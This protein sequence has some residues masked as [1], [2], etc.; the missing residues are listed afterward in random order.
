MRIEDIW[1]RFLLMNEEMADTIEYTYDSGGM[2]LTE[3]RYVR[4]SIAAGG[5]TQTGAVI[6]KINITYT[7]DPVSGN[8]TKKTITIDTIT[9]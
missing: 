5:A 8:I 9:P 3:T 6:K 2:V 4:N 7:R 1:N